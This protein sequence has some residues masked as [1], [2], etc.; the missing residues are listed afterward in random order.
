[1]LFLACNSFF[2]AAKSSGELQTARSFPDG[3]PMPKPQFSAVFIWRKMEI[4]FV[5]RWVE[6]FDRVCLAFCFVQFHVGRF[7]S[8]PFGLWYR[9]QFLSICCLPPSFASVNSISFGRY[10]FLFLLQTHTLVFFWWDEEKVVFISS[11]LQVCNQI[12][13]INACWLVLERVLS[14][15]FLTSSLNLSKLMNLRMGDKNKLSPLWY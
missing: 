15:S 11:E 4:W 2:P 10:I 1:M 7:E 13:F 14:T 5:K 9:Q 6:Q 8:R 12:E 3:G